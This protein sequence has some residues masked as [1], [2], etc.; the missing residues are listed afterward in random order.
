MLI[1]ELSA[2]LQKHRRASLDDITLRLNSSPDAVK[3]MLALLAR[4]HKVREVTGPGG[5]CGGCHRCGGGQTTV[6]E[7]VADGGADA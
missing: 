4:K 5:S 6:Y 2:Y 7:W 3:A 1:S